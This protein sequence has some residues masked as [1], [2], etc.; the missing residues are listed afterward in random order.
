MGALDS[1][2]SVPPHLAFA[3]GC[4]LTTVV[5]A[6]LCGGAAQGEGR[7]D[8]WGLGDLQGGARRCSVEFVRHSPHTCAMTCSVV[9]LACKRAPRSAREVSQR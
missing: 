2:A 7:R 8:V 6:S 1:V 4:C 5:S 3:A 9:R